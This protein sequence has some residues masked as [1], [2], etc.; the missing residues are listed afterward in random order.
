MNLKFLVAIVL[1][2]ATMAPSLAE[3]QT[4]RE[5]SDRYDRP[6]RHHDRDWKGWGNRWRQNDYRHYDNSGWGYGYPRDY[7]WPYGRSYNLGNGRLWTPRGAR[8][9]RLPNGVTVYLPR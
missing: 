9:Y 3:A 5:R 2:A 1:A 7:R 8:V 4:R 6:G